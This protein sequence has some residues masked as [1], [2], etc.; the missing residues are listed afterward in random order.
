MP[1]P[2]NLG[3]TWVAEFARLKAKYPDIQIRPKST[4]DRNRP[5]EAPQIDF[6]SWRLAGN[7]SKTSAVLKWR[8]GTPSTELKTPA[9][10]TRPTSRREA[11]NWDFHVAN[12]L[13]TLDETLRAMASIDKRQR[14][15]SREAEAEPSDFG[16]DT[17]SNFPKGRKKYR[18]HTGRERDS[19]IVIKA[20]L[21]RFQETGKLECEVCKFDFVGHYGQHG[22]GFAE[23]HH[24]VPVSVL[25]GKTKTKISDLAIVC[26]NCHRMLHRGSPLPTINSLREMLHRASEA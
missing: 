9:S 11:R 1:K 19:S 12:V 17:E 20:K 26:S 18:M 8:G 5:H 14:N 7:K 6:G 2:Q 4:K 3:S 13:P 16:G 22:S 21:L 25:D 23:A 10:W 24:L 15:E